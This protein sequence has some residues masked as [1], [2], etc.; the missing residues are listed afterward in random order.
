MLLNPPFPVSK[1][2]ASPGDDVTPLSGMVPSTSQ[3]P[4][5]VSPLPVGA[6]TNPT[7]PRTVDLE[8][9]FEDVRRQLEAARATQQ[10]PESMSDETS[11]TSESQ[12]ED[13]PA[14]VATD[15]HEI[16]N[17]FLSHHMPNTLPDRLRRDRELQERRLKQHDPEVLTAAIWGSYK[18]ITAI[19]NDEVD[20]ENKNAFR[21]T[22][23]QLFPFFSAFSKKIKT[24]GF[25]QVVHIPAGIEHVDGD[26]D[27]V[28]LT[29]RDF[30]DRLQRIKAKEKAM[31]LTKLHGYSTPDDIPQE[32]VL[33]AHEINSSIRLTIAGGT[34]IP[35]PFPAHLL[36]NVPAVQRFIE[37]ALPGTFFLDHTPVEVE[38]ARILYGV[39]RDCACVY[40]ENGHDCRKAK[41]EERRVFSPTYTKKLVGGVP[42]YVPPF[43]LDDFDLHAAHYELVYPGACFLFGKVPP[44]IS[45]A[46]A[47]FRLCGDCGLS[48][49]VVLN[50]P[51]FTMLPTP[52]SLLC[53]FNIRLLA[54]KFVKEFEKAECYLAKPA[55]PYSSGRLFVRD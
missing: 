40:L 16:G 12:T 49:R 7:A 21:A 53:P 42:Y 45:D 5:C 17:D 35:A 51:P 31:S 54:E 36:R 20:N 14:D 2:I 13:E 22:C 4:I 8:E 26:A 1:S 24:Q 34:S 6:P 19:L 10:T 15:L 47:N 27:F 39:C 33:M 9:I 37:I 38:T 30:L 23:R 55:I 28:I 43:L 41:I 46:R 18:T 25:A 29:G 50:S 44:A 48:H 32:D 3:A 52:P 11:E